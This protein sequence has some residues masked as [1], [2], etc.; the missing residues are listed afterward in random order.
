MLEN[1]RKKII[2]TKD[3]D[4][5]GASPVYVN[6][7][8]CPEIKRLLGQAASKKE[9]SE[10]SLFGFEMDRYSLEKLRTLLH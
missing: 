6:E 2:M 4:F 5:A 9:G 7:H 3:L 10:R 8:L 1:S